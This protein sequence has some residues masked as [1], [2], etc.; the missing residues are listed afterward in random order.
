MA[1]CINCGQQLGESARHCANCGTAAAANQVPV[2]QQNYGSGFSG[3]VNDPDFQAFAK[4][5]NKAAFIFMAIAV[6]IAAIAILIFAQDNLGMA[7]LTLGIVL[8]LVLIFTIAGQQKAKKT[9][10]GILENKRIERKKVND[11]TDSNSY[12]YKD[13]PVLYFRSGSGKRIRMELLSASGIFEYYQIGDVVRKHPN[14]TY[15][16]KRDKQQELLCINCG[17]I[18]DGHLDACP[19]CKLPALK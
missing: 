10:D 9:W 18:Y 17:R 6:V 19:K 15:P 3:R 16:E 13:V 5:M 12:Y 2:Y 11:N 1:F 8:V 4:K 14:F 7:F